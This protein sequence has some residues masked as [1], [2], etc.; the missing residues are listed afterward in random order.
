M[1]AGMK[2]LTIKVP[3]P[4]AR[5]LATTARQ[6]KKTPAEVASDTL[7]NVARSPQPSLGDLVADL[8]GI[9]QGKYTDLSTNK[10]HLEDFGR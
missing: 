10:K 8:A 3:E 2:T 6:R 9:G 7:A 5:W 1:M 4:A